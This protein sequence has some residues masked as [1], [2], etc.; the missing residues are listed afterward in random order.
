MGLGHSPVPTFAISSNGSFMVYIA[1]NEDGTRQLWYRSLEDSS[2]RPIP[3]TVGAGF[4]PMISP[5]GTRVA[6]V[7]V[8]G[9]GMEVAPIDGGPV[10]KVSNDRDPWGGGWLGDGTIFYARR[11]NSSL[12]WVNPQTGPV[13]DLYVGYCP[14][15]EPL[16]ASEV[17]CGG[18]DHKFAE[19]G[20]VDETPFTLRPV[21]QTT[22]GGGRRPLRGSEF[23][24][25]GGKYLVYTSVDAS[26]MATKFV[27]RDSLLVGRSVALIEGV[28]RP[29]YTGAGYY[30]LGRDGTLVYAPGAN[31]EVSV[32]V[33]R[34]LDGKEDTLPGAPARHLRF[35][36]SPGGRKLASVVEGIRE[37]RLRLYDLDTGGYE[38]LDEAPYLSTPFWGAGGRELIYQREWGDSSEVVAQRLNS[39]ARPRVLLADDPGALVQYVDSS[40]MLF[41]ITG[42]GRGGIVAVDAS[43]HPA[44]VDTVISTPTLMARI[45]PDRRWLVWTDMAA[46]VY[47]A[48]WPKLDPRW[49]LATGQPFEPYW[50]PDG[51]ILLHDPG[52]RTY[53]IAPHPGAHPYG[54]LE[55][56]FTDPHMEETPGW[57]NSIA[58][59]GEVVYPVMPDEFHLRYVRVVP[60]WVAH[61]EHAVDEANR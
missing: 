28:A 2:A 35:N 49:T 58:S 19:V 52:G 1:R 40:L 56:R 46:T 13:R 39:S 21:M 44:H 7:S 20:N 17:I 55:L 22:A 16:S 9:G 15:P 12:R 36:I 11:D 30:A 47:L 23:H 50:L 27:D 61:M 53:T 18:G 42:N 6:F 4:Q 45:S 43:V 14:M 37:Q 31:M 34:A 32:L 38:V 59:D 33:R 51:A 54:P 48:R 24:L 26:I 60:H 25:V 5:D 8:P 10:T 29:Y 3:G 57:S 41:S